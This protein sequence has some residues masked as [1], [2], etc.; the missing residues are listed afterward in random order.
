LL[1]QHR[2]RSARAVVGYK[3]LLGLIAELAD[4]VKRLPELGEFTPVETDLVDRGAKTVDPGSG[5][6]HLGTFATLQT[7]QIVDGVDFRDWQVVRDR[8]QRVLHCLGTDALRR[9]LLARLRDYVA[10]Q[11]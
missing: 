11:T 3:E 7:S 8:S 1:S 5:P 2:E 10:R 4:Q 9:R 6:K